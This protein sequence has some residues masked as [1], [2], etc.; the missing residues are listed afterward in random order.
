MAGRDGN[1]FRFFKRDANLLPQ[2]DFS[3]PGLNAWLPDCGRRN[4]TAAALS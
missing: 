4:C 1:D 2:D 3:I